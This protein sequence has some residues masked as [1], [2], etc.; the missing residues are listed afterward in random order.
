M[1]EDILNISLVY[2]LSRPSYITQFSKVN[3]AI[4]QV[5]DL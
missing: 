5:T 2:P 3:V 1:I 4:F